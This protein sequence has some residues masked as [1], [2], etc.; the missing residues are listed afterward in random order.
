MLLLP[1][2]QHSRKVFKGMNAYDGNPQNTSNP[3]HPKR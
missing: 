2:D 1:Q 3:Y